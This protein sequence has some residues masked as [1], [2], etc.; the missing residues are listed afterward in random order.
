MRNLLFTFVLS[1]GS[2][3]LF[4]HH[5]SY[6]ASNNSDLNIKMWDNSNFTIKL[7]HKV[8]KRTRSFN[9]KNVTQKIQIKK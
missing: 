4:A 3:F 8:A 9:L 1:I 7:D 6:G 2:G 5:N